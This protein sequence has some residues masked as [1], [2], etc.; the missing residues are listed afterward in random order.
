MPHASRRDALSLMTGALFVLSGQAA[1]AFG[2]DDALGHV[3]ATIDDILALIVAHGSQAETARNLRRII[4]QRTAIGFVARFSAGR[5]W[6]EMSDAQKSAFEDAFTG[7]IADEYARHFRRFEGQIDDLR[8]FVRIIDAEDAGRKGILVRTEILPIN[9]LPIAIDWLVSDRSGRV[10]IND[11]VVEGIS[12]A[13]T[14]REVIGGMI[15]ARSGDLD[16]VIDD[17][18]ARSAGG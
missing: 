10:A 15:E 16:R 2:P 4:E 18:R 17:L 7:Y 1:R 13:I 8:K 5:A 6:R 9:E 11:L 12:M 3:E 14:Q